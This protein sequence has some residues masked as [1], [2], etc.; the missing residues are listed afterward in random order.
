MWTPSHF[1]YQHRYTNHFMLTQWDI[2]DLSSSLGLA[3]TPDITFIYSTNI[4][5]IPST[6]LGVGNKSVDKRDQKN[7][8]LIEKQWG[9]K[10]VNQC[11]KLIMKLPKYFVPA[12]YLFPPLGNEGVGPDGPGRP[13][14]LGSESFP[15]SCCF[16]ASPLSGGLAPGLSG[17]WRLE[18]L[19]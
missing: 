10:T 7:P 6:I 8:F 5:W 15:G 1:T 18:S 4:Y 14:R 17:V 2:R 3:S 16:Q 19:V 13:R 12:H 11:D 9:E